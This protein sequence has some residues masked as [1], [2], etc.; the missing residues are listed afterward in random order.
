MNPLKLIIAAAAGYGYY[1]Y[2]KMT[3][4]EKNEFMRK[5]KD[6]VNKNF[7]DINSILGKKETVTNN[8]WKP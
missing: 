6:F 7:G 5:G 1:K 8:N 4:A 3:P 2:S